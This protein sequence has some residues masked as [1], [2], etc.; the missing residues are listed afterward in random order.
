MTP[1]ER[2][3]NQIAQANLGVAQGNLSLARQRFDR[4]GYQLKEGA[5]GQMFYVP[6]APGAAA[7]PVIG[8]GGQPFVTQS[9]APEK[10]STTAKKLNDLA[11]VIKSYR[12]EVESDKVV[13]PTSI[14]LPFD[15][16]IPL[17]TGA[18]SARMR[19]KYQALLMGVKDLYE[20]G[21]LTGPDMGI[22]SEQLTNPASISGVFTSRNAMKEQITVLEDML[23]RA[24][25]NTESAYKRKLPAASETR[26][27][28][29]V[30][31]PTTGM[32]EYRED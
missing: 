10:F 25:A 9:Q 12:Q 27:P 16:K 28:R 29:L 22:I 24:R 17:P 20:L 15:A 8:Q 26:A 23:A 32:L 30:T 5:E 7:V 21:A 18:D 13:F 19:G 2:A 3:S 6:T 31:N 1:G 11:G 14:P 4:E